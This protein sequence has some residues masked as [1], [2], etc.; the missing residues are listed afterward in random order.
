[1]RQDASTG[2][3]NCDATLQ[4]QL[5]DDATYATDAAIADCVNCI[6]P[7]SEG[8]GGTGGAAGSEGQGRAGAAGTS[9]F[10]FTSCSPLL[11]RCDAVCS[12]IPTFQQR[13]QVAS[14][15]LAVCLRGVKNCVRPAPENT[16]GMG[17][18]GGAAPE[19][20]ATPNITQG[21]VELDVCYR[22]LLDREAKGSGSNAGKGGGSGGAS[23]NAE[24]ASLSEDADLAFRCAECEAK[25]PTCCD[26]ITN[27]AD[28]VSLYPP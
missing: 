28:C 8:K 17:G 4:A 16:A 20:V 11:E 23:G 27:C 1:M 19:C 9:S 6:A 13:F 18:E 10:E 24:K 14:A 12:S 3:A 15:R 5:H 7:D 22:D 21:P 25:N 26:L 2:A